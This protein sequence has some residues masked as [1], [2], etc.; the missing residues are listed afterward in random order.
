MGGEG[1]KAQLYFASSLSFVAQLRSSI[2]MAHCFSQ[3]NDEVS[4]VITQTIV[5]QDKYGHLLKA[6]TYPSH[7][8]PLVHGS[9]GGGG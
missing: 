9:K 5:D 4:P 8:V 1:G 3:Q 7:A 2:E 6:T